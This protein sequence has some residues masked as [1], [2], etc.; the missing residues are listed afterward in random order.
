MDEHETPVA[1]DFWTAMWLLSTVV[2]RRLTVARPRTPVPLNLYVMLCAESG[3]TRK[4]TAIIEAKSVLTCFQ[5]QHAAFRTPTIIIDNNVPTMDIIDEMQRSSISNRC[6]PVTFVGAEGA[7]I[8]PRRNSELPIYLTDWYDCPTDRNSVGLRD[9]Y[10]TVLVASTPAWLIRAI[11]PAVIEGGFTS[12]CFFVVSERGKRRIP[13]PSQSQIDAKVFASILVRISRIAE[14]MQQI[15]IS[16]PAL[17]RYSDW[18]NSREVPNDSFRQSFGAR[19]GDHV[20]KVAGLLA[21]NDLSFVITRAHVDNA[22]QCVLDVRERGATLFVSSLAA[23]SAT[24]LVDSVRTFLIDAGIDGISNGRVMAKFRRD[25]DR[26]RI[27]LTILHELDLVQRFQAPGNS[28]RKVTTW[29]GTSKLS[30]PG[31]VDAVLHKLEPNVDE[32]VTVD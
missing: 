10:S 9:V 16:M 27:I 25:P 13:W 14:T 5:Q 23:D 24:R 32:R 8:L 15:E 21:V 31:V 4:T 30:H 20:L 19:E 28:N 1:Y 6:A 2:G 11:N 7:L 22:L 3:T 29:R 18:Y 17:A 12:R 26:V